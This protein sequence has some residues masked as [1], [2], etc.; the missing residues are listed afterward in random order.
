VGTQQQQQ[1]EQQEQQLQRV[2]RFPRGGL[3]QRLER[4]VLEELAAC[5]EPLLGPSA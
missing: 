4:L 5:S 1:Q 3:V 2:R